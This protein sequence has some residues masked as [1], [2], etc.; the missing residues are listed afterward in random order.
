MQ[1]KHQ[2][3]TAEKECARTSGAVSLQGTDICWV[4]VF[5]E[6]GR[7][8]SQVEMVALA[9]LGRSTVYGDIRT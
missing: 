1:R 8:C 2:E 9:Y 6:Q 7:A 4:S 3:Q 5:C